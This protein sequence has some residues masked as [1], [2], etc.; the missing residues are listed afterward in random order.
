[1]NIYEETTQRILKKLDE[2]VI[3]WRKTWACGLPA[4]LST[5]REY[6][7][8]NILIMSTAGYTSRYWVTFR[9]ALRLGGN[10]RK[11]EKATPIIYWH[12]R[13]PEEPRR[14]HLTAPVALVR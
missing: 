10:V 8:I 1:M 14:L 13:T 2:G 4:S 6:R 5:G 12:W 9:E 7:G 11:G 3:P